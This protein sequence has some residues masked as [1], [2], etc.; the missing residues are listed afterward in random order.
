METILLREQQISPTEEVI[1]NALGDSYSAYKDLIEA[2]TDTGYGL[3][4][5]WNYYKDGKA[6]LCKVCY[7]K[8]TVFWL[9]VWDK[10]FKTTFYFTEKTGSGIE[11]LDIEEK[12]KESFSNNKPIGKLIPLTITIKSKDQIKDVLTVS[13]YK[14]NLK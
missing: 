1:E 10:F 9:S 4:P 12:I 14:K 6:W 11:G 5:Q 7:K 3:V 8:K 2:I 13:K